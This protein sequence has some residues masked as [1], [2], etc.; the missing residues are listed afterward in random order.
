VPIPGTASKRVPGISAAGTW[1]FGTG[2][3][4]SAVAW[5][6]SVGAVTRTAGPAGPVSR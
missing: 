5:L 4:G 1:P 2:S 6:T 3:S